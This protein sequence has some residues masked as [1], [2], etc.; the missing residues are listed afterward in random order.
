MEE[1]RGAH[2]AC[3][4]ISRLYKGYRVLVAQTQTYT[5][6]GRPSYSA[7]KLIVAI[8]VAKAGHMGRAGHGTGCEACLCHLLSHLCQFPFN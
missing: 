5:Y 6:G 8:P 4:R 2:A 1:L 7:R 3:V